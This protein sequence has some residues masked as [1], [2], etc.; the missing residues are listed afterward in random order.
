[1]TVAPSSLSTQY[2]TNLKAG[3]V[4]SGFS[5]SPNLNVSYD[6]KFLNT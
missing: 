3:V 6:V 4:V 2:V 1:M 5:T